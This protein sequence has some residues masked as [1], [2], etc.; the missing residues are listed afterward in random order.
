[1]EG[2]SGDPSPPGSSNHRRRSGAVKRKAATAALTALSSLSATLNAP[3]SKRQSKERNPNLFFQSSHH[4]GPLTRAR[5]SPSK[6]PWSGSNEALDMEMEDLVGGAG[7][8]LVMVG[9]ETED[10]L[11]VGKEE[12][13]SVVD[14]EFE[15]VKSR[16]KDVHVVPTFSGWFSWNTIHGIEKQTLVSFFDGKSE[17]RNPES[18]LQIRNSIMKKFHSNPQSKIDPKSLSDLSSEDNSD[19]YK[20]VLEF[21]DHWGLINFHPFPPTG[22]DSTG[23]DPTGDKKVDYDPSL[24]DK[25][26]QFETNQLYVAAPVVKKVQPAVQQ[27]AVQQQAVPALVHGEPGL[28]EDLLAPIEPS[29][30][31]HCNSCSADCSRKRYHCRTQADFDLCTDCY[32]AGKFA[33]R[34]TSADFIL[35]ESVEA[36]AGVGGASWTDE[37]TLLLLEAL[38]LFGANWNEI[39]DHVGTKSKAQCMMHFL[40]MP[41]QDSFLNEEMMEKEEEKKEEED[42]KG[43]KEEKDEK[44]EKEEK[45]EEEGKDDDVAVR[46]L[47]EAFESVGCFE[48]MMD[49]GFSFADAGNPVMALAAF[50]T[51]LVEQD[52][53]SMTT[54][55]KS[56]LKAMSESS[57]SLQLATRHCFVL[58]DPPND[59]VS[60]PPDTSSS[61]ACEGKTLDLENSEKTGDLNEKEN[62]KKPDDLNEKENTEKMEDLN[63]KGNDKADDDQ[64][65]NNEEN[66]LS[67]DLNAKDDKSESPSENKNNEKEKQTSNNNNDDNDNI[68]SGDL[69]E[70]VKSEGE[71]KESGPSEKKEEIK[72]ENEKDEKCNNNIIRLKRAASTA[73]SSAAVKAKYLAKQEEDQIR[74]LV[75]V[76]IDKQFRKMEA[77]L[78]M[79]FELEG[80]IARVKEQTDK[81]RQRLLHERSQIIAARLGLQNPPPFRNPNPNPNP[82]PSPNQQAA[83]ANRLAA[84][85]ASAMAGGQRP[86]SNMMSNMHIRRP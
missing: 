62:S 65:E 29:I 39:A 28:G 43:E 54:H 20:E 47:K 76:I 13:E 77:K 35:M 3:V 22:D 10:L 53:G 60:V 64:K 31:Y 19:S 6:L 49:P 57:P 34:M 74:Q 25:L 36:P 86:P 45:E 4:S 75:T 59:D 42:E 67:E 81:V 80:M 68:K 15:A 56:S 58:E 21:L 33:E 41:I 17:N 79:F 73:L 46:V 26:Y 72:C 83:N 14:L 27:Q 82:N 30:E 8:D 78:A 1:M 52:K 40:Q 55:H 71:L 9:E 18:Y 66:K 24:L 16:A 7:L 44:V 70:I 84:A 2:N 61:G 51:G 63:E 50:L 85:Y 48:E 12:E 5:Q 32:T 37:E 69:L 23:E 11:S 38:E